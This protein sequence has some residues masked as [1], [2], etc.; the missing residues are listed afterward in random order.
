MGSKHLSSIVTAV[1]APLSVL[2]SFAI[3][4][5]ISKSKDKLHTTLN[6][7]LIGLCIGDLLASIPMAF[8]T[9]IIKYEER[10]LADDNGEM[11]S[12]QIPVATNQAACH[13]QG[14]FIVLGGILSPFYN[15]ALCLYYVC[16]VKWNYSDAKITRNIEPFL[17]AIP[18]LWALRSAIIAS[19]TNSIHPF[20][21]MCFM[22]PTPSDCNTVD[23]IECEEG[24][25]AEQI[26][27]V[28]HTF[29]MLVI[30]FAICIQMTVVYLHVRRQERRLVNAGFRSA[31]VAQAASGGRRRSSIETSMIAGRQSLA[32]ANASRGV[33]RQTVSNSRKVLNQA[34]AYVGAYFCTYFFI[35]LLEFISLVSG[36]SNATISLIAAF[37]YPLQGKIVQPVRCA[38]VVN[39]CICMS[40]YVY[41]FISHSLT[42]TK[43]SSTSL[44]SYFP[45]YRVN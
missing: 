7:L 34:L 22:H 18:W 26:R 8:S 40:I 2:G 9:A 30:F 24:Q 13:T 36:E 21:G 12:Y 16:V 17:H 38:I 32:Q 23:S 19:A 11:I 20:H 3:I 41:I 29:P 44:S 15:C 42:T 39:T 45:E 25:N 43:V 28:S 6:R 14:F 1:P 35:F 10:S 33:L 31:N 37:L 5:V 27:F 4:H